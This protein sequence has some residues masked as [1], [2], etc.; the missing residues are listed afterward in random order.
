VTTVRILCRVTISPSLCFAGPEAVQPT[1]L[2][3]KSA[4]RD[5]E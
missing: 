3:E 5:S 1:W 4:G 2:I